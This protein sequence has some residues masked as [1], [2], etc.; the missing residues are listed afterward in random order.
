MLPYKDDF[1]KGGLVGVKRLRYSAKV[2]GGCNAK[3]GMMLKSIQFN[4][5]S[6]KG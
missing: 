3:I 6:L 5:Q 4:M 1:S 2:P